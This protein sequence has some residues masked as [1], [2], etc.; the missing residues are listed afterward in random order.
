MNTILVLTSTLQNTEIYVKLEDILD[1][2]NTIYV[3]TVLLNEVYTYKIGLENGLNFDYTSEQCSIYFNCTLVFKLCDRTQ[4]T[5]FIDCFVNSSVQEIMKHQFHHVRSKR[6]F[7]SFFD[8]LIIVFCKKKFR[9]NDFVNELKVIFGKAESIEYLN[10]ELDT[11]ELHN[12]IFKSVFKFIKNRIG[13][14]LFPTFY[15]LFVCKLILHMH[16]RVT[17]ARIQSFLDAYSLN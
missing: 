4:L 16:T 12:D 9:L 7:L 17:D 11:N 1:P 5:Q 3:R 15:K 13:T 14:S 8:D 10:E 6:P 2:L